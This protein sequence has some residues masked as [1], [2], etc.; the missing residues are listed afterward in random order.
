MNDEDM[1]PGKVWQVYDPITLRDKFAMAAPVTP[2]M[3]FQPTMPERPSPGFAVG[4]SGR[5]YANGFTAEKEEGDCWEWSNQKAVDEWEDEKRRQHSI[6]WPYFYAD[7]M[8]K[9]R[10]A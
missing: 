10:Q 5:R 7:A 3:H 1:L 9:A 8:L 2:W 4:E 6:Q